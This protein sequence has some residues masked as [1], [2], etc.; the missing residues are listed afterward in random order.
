M[1]DLDF[2]GQIVDF[3][4]HHGI[5]VLSDLAYAEVYFDGNPPPSVL[6]IPGAKDIAVEFT[7]MS[8]TYNMPGWRVGFAAGNPD[9]IAALGRVKSY[10]DY[11]A[12]TPI[13]VAATAALNG[14]QDCVEEMRQ[15][16]AGRRDILVHGLRSAGW[17]CPLPHD[18]V[19][20]GA[21]PPRRDM[22]A[23]GFTKA[24][25]AEADLLSRPASVGGS[26]AIS[27]RLVENGH[28]VRQAVRNIR[29]FAP[30][31]GG[32]RLAAAS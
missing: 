14:P 23:I 9:L 24:L 11:G 22:G 21:D 27:L 16:Y 20:V 4:R 31:W 2:Y 1:V 18:H 8:K 12:F 25:L 19:R 3:C 7:S 13:Q 28:R 30:P 10:L 6:E 5:Y 32:R 17:D 15:L 29:G 26:E